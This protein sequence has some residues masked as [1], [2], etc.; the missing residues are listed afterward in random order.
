MDYLMQDRTTSPRSTLYNRA[1]RPIVDALLRGAARKC[2]ACGVGA[3]FRRYLKV[4]DNCPHCGEALYHHRADDAP[5]YFTIAIVGH[6]VVG[7]VLLVEMAYR[8]PL[9]LH[10][11]LWLPLTL[12]LALLLLPSVKGTIVALQWALFMHGFDPDGDDEEAL[13]AGK[14]PRSPALTSRRE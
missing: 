7:L 14:T 3:L 2:P 11:V 10:A 1:P 6:V 9:W 8:P 12:I 4:V 5:P 13:A